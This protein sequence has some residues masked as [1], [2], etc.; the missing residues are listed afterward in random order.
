M[1]ETAQLIRAYAVT[2]GLDEAALR[3]AWGETAARHG[4]ADAEGGLFT[5][6]GDLAAPDPW[7]AAER[8]WADPESLV[9]PAGTGPAARLAVG[10]PLAGG[11]LLVLAVN[12]AFTAAGHRLAPLADALGAAY[13]ERVGAD[14]ATVE[15]TLDAGTAGAVSALAAG[16][17]A[18]PTDV[19]LAAYACLIG[20]HHGTDRPHLAVRTP[21]D[22]RT[23]LT[24]DLSSAP[25]FRT[26]VRRIAAAPQADHETSASGAFAVEGADE[27]VLRL[28]G[29]RVRRLRAGGALPGG[30]DPVLTVTAGPAGPTRGLLEYRPVPCDT[31]AATGLLGQLRILLKAALAAPDASVD[32]LPLETGEQLRAAVRAADLTGATP[33]A[34]P[35]VNARVRASARAF[36][37]VPALDGD[38]GPVPYRELTAR[39]TRITNAL[40]AL[41]VGEGSAVALRLPNGPGQAAALLGVLDAGAHAVGLAPKDSGERVKAVLAGLRPEV[42]VV[43]GEEAG[44]ALPTWFRAEVGGRVLDLDSL[45]YLPPG[46]VPSAADLDGDEQDRWAYVAYT[47]GSTGTPKGIPQ[48]HRT[49]GRFV[50]WFASAFGIGPGSRVAQW[51]QPGYDAGLVELFAALTTGATLCPV[52]DR[53]RAHPEKLAAWLESERITHFQTVPSFARELLTA[54]RATGGAPFSLRCLLLAGEP[55]GGELADGLRA[56]LPRTRVV[57]LYGAT[58]TVLATWH[59]VDA[60]VGAGT[61]PIGRPVPGRQVLVLDEEDRPCPAGV[62]G[63]IVVCGPY[64]TPGYLGADRLD[65]AFRPVSAGPDGAGAAHSGCY[66]SGDLGRRRFDGLL[67]FRGRGDERIKIHGTRLELTDLEA[68][69]AADPSVRSCAVV[70]RAADDGLVAGLVAYVV[71]HEGPEAPDASPAAWRATLRRWFGPALPAL[72]FVTIDRLPHNTGGKVDRRALADRATA[73]L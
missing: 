22:D 64:V 27:P 12:R 58:E 25:S 8:L 2:D 47:S 72:T 71:P 7:E 21:D 20:R 63:R 5:D 36:G 46:P 24:V 32:T 52:P 59:E 51:A 53:L 40:R 73:M 10:R 34:G 50:D 60:P 29:A 41:G 28:A 66:R 56:A 19:L 61:V 18:G 13:A 45:T 55:L 42:L 9:F 23:A 14:P 54:L 15:F 26:L 35:P 4:A 67:E 16:E 6:L 1:T 3:A 30:A 38:G 57:N 68:A 69:L 37:D 65:G 39:A 49:F 44:A 17:D 11:H 43:A 48:T 31:A 62:T 70:A 33:Q